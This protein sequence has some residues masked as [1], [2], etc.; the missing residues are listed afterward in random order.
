MILK[1][2]KRFVPRWP[3]R[4]PPSPGPGELLAYWQQRARTYGRRAVM[5]LG[6]DEDAVD[7][8]TRNQ[9]ATL[10]P[11][12][13]K[14]LRGDECVALD[15][16]C[17]PGRF[18]AQLAEAIGG[19]AIGVDPILPLLQLAPRWR[20]VDYLVSDGRRIPL[21]D[22]SV[23]VAWVCLV[24]GGLPDPQLAEAVAELERVLRPGGL[25]FLV[26]NTSARENFRHWIFRPVRRYQRLFRSVPLAHLHDYYDLGERV[27]ILAGRKT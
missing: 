18:T 27:S 10:F 26:E 15:F 4:H 3:R 12:L 14:L 9:R 20:G 5:N 17:G 11:Y 21:A 2:L 1:L 16:G 23:D 6:H 19:R 13:T 7:A 24:L 8:V 25:L 22:A